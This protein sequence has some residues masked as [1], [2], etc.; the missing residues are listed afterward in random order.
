[1]QTEVI[2]E[3]IDVEGLAVHLE[4][5]LATDE[6]EAAA[7]LQ[8]KIA[9]M[10]E[11]TTL[12]LPLFGG[13]A[14]GQKLERVWV[15]EDLLR[16]VGL[17]CR[18]RS[19]EVRQRLPLPLAKLSGDEVDSTLR[20]QP[21]SRAARRYHSRLALLHAIEQKHLVTPRQF[22]SKLQNW[23]VRP[24]LGEGPH[25]T[26]TPEAEALDPGKL[27]A[28][29]LCQPIHRLVPHPSAAKREERSCPM[30]Q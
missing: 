22:C 1:M 10:F 13:R 17:R 30:D 7:Q 18:Q 3:Q 27:V 15:L 6:G 11:E 26:E 20:P 28:E 8:Q 9:Q 29:V 23:R 2:E 24:R 4:R 25:I 21:F 19:V 14:Q 5:H 12:E 16:Q